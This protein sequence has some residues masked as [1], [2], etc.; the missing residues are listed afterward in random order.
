MKKNCDET[1]SESTMRR[2]GHKLPSYSVVILSNKKRADRT[3]VHQ[4]R[5]HDTIVPSKV[6]Y[7]R[8]EIMNQTEKWIWR[9]TFREASPH[10]SSVWGFP[11]SSYLLEPLI[12]SHH[13]Q[14]SFL[15]SLRHLRL[16]RSKPKVRLP[17]WLLQKCFAWLSAKP[18]RWSHRTDR[19]FKTHFES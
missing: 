18:T 3:V 13:P 7:I 12:G 8:K 15:F 11:S 4:G 1:S 9:R 19:K 17:V 6:T 16:I 5:S 14:T 2:G 10:C